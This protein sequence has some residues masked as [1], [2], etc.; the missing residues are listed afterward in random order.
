MAEIQAFAVGPPRSGT[1]WLANALN[2]GAEVFSFHEC[3]RDVIQADCATQQSIVRRR[4][5]SRPEFAAVN[6]SSGMLN[7]EMPE[8][9][10]II[11]RP[12]KDVKTS[13]GMAFLEWEMDIDDIIGTDSDAMIS[14]LA[15]EHTKCV[16]NHPHALHVSFDDLFTT[17]ALLA[18]WQELF[19]ML[20]PPID[21]FKEV[22]R[23]RVTLKHFDYSNTG[24]DET[25][26]AQIQTKPKRDED[27]CFTD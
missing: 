6:V 25:Q 24:E 13:L 16:L 27:D 26:Q 2:Y 19:P 10:V 14:R 5:D 18:I 20:I 17:Q 8:P 12:W 9:L 3:E 11:H 7:W 23:Q 22:V 21:R 15:E 1:A 4:M